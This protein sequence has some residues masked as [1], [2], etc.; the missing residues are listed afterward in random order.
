[1]LG[2]H[3]DAALERL[4]DLAEFLRREQ[5]DVLSV[6]DELVTVVA[7]Q[8]EV[9]LGLGVEAAIIRLLRGDSAPPVAPTLCAS[10]A[11]RTECI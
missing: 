11:K 4:L 2:D 6:I 1:M 5:I 10:S 8:Q 3:L 7:E 9:L